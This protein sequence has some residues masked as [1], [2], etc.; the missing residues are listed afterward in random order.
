[1]AST[2]D[3]GEHR[4]EDQSIS[5]YRTMNHQSSHDHT[6]VQSDHPCYREASLICYSNSNTNAALNGP[7]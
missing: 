6:A 5:Q 4:N 1:M 3:G 7:S 2:L